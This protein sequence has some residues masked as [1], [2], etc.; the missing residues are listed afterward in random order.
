MSFIEAIKTCF[1]KY[2]TFSGRARRS[3]HWYFFLFI[4][5]IQIVLYSWIMATIMGPMM[6]FIQEGGDP[7]DVDTIKEIFLGSITSPAFI[8][9]I[10]FSLAT[11]L[12]IIAV[13]IRRMHDTG[14]SGWWSMTYWG[15][16]LLSLVGVPFVSIVGT[17]WFIY[18]A[19]QDSTPGTNIYGP[20]PKG[21][22]ETSS[23][24]F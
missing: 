3:E 2:I 24:N 14:R 23:T 21:L 8:V 9:F 7:K 16:T 5:L 4:T 19:C 11:L 17:I 18:L 15:G 6:E 20:N 13:Q 22:E 10:V 1:A 12:P